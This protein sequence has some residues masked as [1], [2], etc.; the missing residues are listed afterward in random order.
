[1][2]LGGSGWFWVFLGISGW[3]WVFLGVSGWF[4]VVLGGSGSR[5]WV[6]GKVSELWILGRGSTVIGC[7]IWIYMSGSR[8]QELG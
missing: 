5:F 3:L 7:G 6:Q 8:V 1:M 4:W 2:V